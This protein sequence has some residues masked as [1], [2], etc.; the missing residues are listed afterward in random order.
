LSTGR[1]GRAVTRSGRSSAPAMAE[2]R[3]SECEGEAKRE[4]KQGREQQL[5]VLKKVEGRE[6]VAW[7]AMVAP[8]RAQERPTTRNRA[9]EWPCAP[10]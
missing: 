1:I 4:G 5:G 6:S 8:V 2:S 10:L 3:A 7:A 9:G